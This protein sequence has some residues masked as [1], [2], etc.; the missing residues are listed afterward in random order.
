MADDKNNDH[1]IKDKEIFY[2]LGVFIVVLAVPV[3]IGTFFAGRG[4]AMVVNAAAGLV[5]LAIG[6][7]FILRGRVKPK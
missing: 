1:A 7:A 4:H 6:V 5:L 2:L 3:L